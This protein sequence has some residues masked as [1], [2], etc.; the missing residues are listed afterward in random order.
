MTSLDEDLRLARTADAADR[1]NHRD[2][3]ARH[4]ADAIQAVAPWLSDPDLCRFA[5]RVIWRAGDMGDRE[6]AVAILR[7]ALDDPTVATDRGDVVF[8]LE[9]LGYRIPTGRPLGPKPIPPQA[10]LGWPGFQPNEF[11]TTDGTHWRGKQ[12]A[13][14]LMPHILRPLREI[15]PRF[16]S[17]AIY[18]L[19]E[20]H[21]A[22]RDRYIQ[23]GDW[24]QRFRAAKLVVYAH[25][26]SSER[27]A[28]PLSV[29]VGLYVEKG[30]GK[31][32]GGQVDGR[33]DWPA[34]IR[35]LDSASFRERLQRTM[36]TH[37]LRIGDYFGGDTFP[38]SGGIVGFRGHIDGHELVISSND[39][40]ERG[41]DPLVRR[42]RE[43]PAD[44]SHSIH[45]WREWPADAAIAA[46]V[47]FV[48]ASMV[49]VLSDLAPIY[50]SILGSKS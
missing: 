19:P 8:H 40:D 10:G 32:P 1:I 30:S 4:G 14:S 16:D 11:E 9:R 45:I 33:W 12:T 5:I 34:F 46:G 43:L 27:P 24:E 28:D 18:R 13:D 44:D 7:E 36:S 48:R 49:P 39:G 6:A 47:S 31:K 3:I 23:D 15:D 37:E 29:A 26:Q 21:I 20:V 41:W 25:G 2:D 42:L 50:L 22:F 35:C 38:P 17:W